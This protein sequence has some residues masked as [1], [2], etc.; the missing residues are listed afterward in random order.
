MD[1]RGA[2]RRAQVAALRSEDS[3]RELRRLIVSAFPMCPDKPACACRL[4]WVLTGRRG[5]RLFS[6]DPIRIPP[7]WRVG[8][9]RTEEA[10]AAPVDPVERGRYLVTITGCNDCHTPWRMGEQGPEPDMSRMLSGHPEGVVLSP[11]DAGEGPW[12]WHGAAM[13]TAFAGP[14]GISYSTNL[15]PDEE[16]GFGIWTEEMFIA[17]IRDGRHMGRGRPI[18]PPM[19]WQA[20]REMTDEDLRAVFAYLQT[21]PPIRNQVPE[22]QRAP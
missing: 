16:T 10:A 15:N 18:L 17:A 4:A 22:A 3:P 19:P 13:M 20:Y 5:D 21:V 6:T 2:A 9:D 12:L 1:G 7:E 8:G 14:W 11:P